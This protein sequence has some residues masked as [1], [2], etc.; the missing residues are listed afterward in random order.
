MGQLKSRL[1][2]AAFARNKCKQNPVC[3]RHKENMQTSSGERLAGSS[4][5]RKGLQLE[6][7][8][9]EK[10]PLY[11]RAVTQTDVPPQQSHQLSSLPS[12]QKRP[13]GGLGSSKHRRSVVTIDCAPCSADLGAPKPP[14]SVLRQP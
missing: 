8:L 4:S 10:A 2:Q 14:S 12:R 5:S 13:E 11:R 9:L 1:L 3:R 6:K 7:L